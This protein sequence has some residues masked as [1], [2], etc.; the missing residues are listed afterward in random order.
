M[1]VAGALAWYVTTELSVGAASYAPITAIGALGLGR[2]RRIS[3]SV[4]MMAGL[5]VGVIAAE[6]ATPLIGVGW[7]Q[8]GLM[9]AATA[10]IAGAIVDRDLAVT[11]AVINAVV[12]VTAPGTEGWVPDRLISGLIGVG[13]AVLVM[14]VAMPPDPTRIATTRLRRVV[15]LSVEALDETVT[16]LGATKPARS[17]AAIER[18]LIDSARRL[19]DQIERSHESVAQA[20][21][22]VRWSPI[23]RRDR[24]EVERLTEIARELRPAL[25]TVST[26][27]RLGD[28]AALIDVRADDH[29]L[30][31]I[32]SASDAMSRLSGRLLDNEAPPNADDEMAAIAI[33]RLLERP[34]EHAILIAMQEE[35]RGLL[36]DLT[37]I[38]HSRFDGSAPNARDRSRGETLDGIRFG[39]AD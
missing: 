28:R 9:L 36:S 29:V 22:I 31:G 32:R 3:P 13:T 19:D 6:I 39:R 5:F 18:T 11:Y 17:D 10:I 24:A 27:A 7:W 4:L 23:R 15:E 2:E 8:L 25:R 30:E 14:L 35:V 33:D 37:G 1:G 21:E 38:V 34:C 26:I 16:T 20:N 12:L